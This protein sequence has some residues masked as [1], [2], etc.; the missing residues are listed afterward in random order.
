MLYDNC[1]GHRGYNAESSAK[2]MK[3]LIEQRLE[4]PWDSDSALTE[5]DFRR[6]K[7]EIDAF[8]KALGGN[9]SN[10]AFIVPEGI[11][12]QDPTSRKFYLKL[13]DI[14]NYERVQI[15]KVLTSNGFIAN[16]MLDA[17]MS[18]HGGKKDLAT[19]KLR[20]LRDLSKD[21]RQN[22][23]INISICL[24][25]IGIRDKRKTAG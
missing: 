1:N 12:K 25:Q 7:V 22:V 17:Y 11:S 13:N 20:E 21:Q 9:F 24:M 4:K 19:K 16:H 6:I 5:G 10:L 14:L 8:D 23:A 2:N 18:I 3:W 15:N